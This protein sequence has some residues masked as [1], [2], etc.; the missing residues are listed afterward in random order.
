MITA[1]FSRRSQ[2]QR[3]SASDRDGRPVRRGDPRTM[4]APSPSGSTASPRSCRPRSTRSS[5]PA[6]RALCEGADLVVT[7]ANQRRAVA[8]R[9]PAAEVTTISFIPVRGDPPGARRDRS[10]R[11]ARRDLAGARVPLDH[12]ARRAPVRAACAR[13]CAPPWSTPR[14]STGCC[15]GRT[16]W[17]IATGAESVA[18]R[19]RAGQRAIAYRHI[20]DPGDVDRLA[21]ALLADGHSFEAGAN[22]GSHARERQRR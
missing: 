1:R 17:S 19:L 7:F 8:A 22:V 9:L 11:P 14:R 21:A 6:A 16:W 3:R 12:E 20:P 5:A 15:P 18:E 10:A 4:P 13:R 2:A